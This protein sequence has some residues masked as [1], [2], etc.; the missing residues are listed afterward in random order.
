MQNYNPIDLDTPIFNTPAIVL[1]NYIISKAHYYNLNLSSI[2]LQAIMF[3]LEGATQA[4]FSTSICKYKHYFVY[5]ITC[6]LPEIYLAYENTPNDLHIKSHVY[7]DSHGKLIS[8]PYPKLN[9]KML[10]SELLSQKDSIKSELDQIIVS[11]LKNRHVIDE[12]IKPDIQ[13]LPPANTSLISQMPEYDP[14]HI[15]YLFIKNKAQ[16]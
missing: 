5:S 12:I 4:K 1:A 7:A 11:L 13:K 14:G 15:A 9:S 3:L 10:S 6:Y 8:E 16:I 2:K